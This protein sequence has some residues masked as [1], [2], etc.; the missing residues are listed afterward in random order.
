MF[1]HFKESH[2]NLVQDNGNY[3][4]FRLIFCFDFRRHVVIMFV[5]LIWGAP[6][7]DLN[8]R[9]PAPSL[10]WWTC[11]IDMLE[12]DLSAVLVCVWGRVWDRYIIST[13]KDLFYPPPPFLN[14]KKLINN[15]NLLKWHKSIYRKISVI[16]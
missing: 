10:R 12:L 3:F 8:A 9:V 14:K 6:H 1:Y 16:V 11:S 2:R 15:T 5:L 4:M 7:I 13:C